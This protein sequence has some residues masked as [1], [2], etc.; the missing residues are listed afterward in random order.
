MFLNVIFICSF[1]MS[2]NVCL[3]IYEGNKNHER[4]DFFLCITLDDLGYRVDGG[5]G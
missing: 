4:E 1:H 2:F 5:I 3:D